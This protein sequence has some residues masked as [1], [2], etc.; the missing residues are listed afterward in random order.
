MQDLERSEAGRGLAL[1]I[2]AYLLWGVFP[3][4]FKA[5]SMVPPLQVTAH[6]IVWS[7]LFMF[8]VICLARRWDGI[9][10]A[11][12]D[13]SSVQILMATSLL[14]GLNWLVFVIAIEHGQVLQ[15]SLG[16]YFSPLV[17]TMLGVVFLK[18]R[19]RRA[20]IISLMLAC[21]GVLILTVHAGVFPWLGLSLAVT[22]SSYGLLRKV[23]K[24]DSIVGLTVET[25][26]LAP[27]ACG[28]L[29]YLAWQGTGVFQTAGTDIDLL[30]IGSGAVTAVPLLLFVA[31]A[32]RLKLATIGFLQYLAP[33]INFFLAVLLYNETFS[34]VHLI[35]FVCIWL[36]VAL[37]SW[38]AYRLVT[39][40]RRQ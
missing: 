22:F 1:G 34:R 16:Y 18:E 23:V 28:Y 32:R 39:K 13:R 20:Q 6:R 4:Y 24:A 26:L 15:C 31:A 21:L 7:T 17:S 12:M 33:T 37:Y 2:S 5:M 38:D 14:I 19:L 29:V 25:F 30:L 35:S 11:V 3:V 27:L 8:L 9:R 10:T 40:L 36:G